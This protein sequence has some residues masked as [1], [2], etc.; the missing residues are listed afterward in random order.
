[1][2]VIGAGTMG[3]GIA[4]V[5]ARAG[6]RTLLHDR[7]PAAIDSAIVRLH[8]QLDREVSKGR[9]EET[10][11]N[12]IASRIEAAPQIA[13]LG[14]AMLLIE[15]ILENADA[16]AALFADLER[17][18]SPDAVLCSN[19][20]SLSITAIGAR[21]ARPERFAGM[22]FF[23]P[24][25][26]MP[27]VEVISGRATSPE[28]A[29]QLAATAKAWG[30]VPVYC[31]ST[32]GFIVNRIARPFY[33]EG[34]RLIE[35]G[36]GDPATID[37]IMTGCGGFRMGPMALTDLIGQDVNFAVTQS[38][39]A[40]TF[41]D[42]RYSPSPIQRDLVEAGW[43]GRKSGRGFY[44]YSAGAEP[45]GPRY[46]ATCPVPRQVVFRGD[47]GPA[48][49]LIELARQSGIEIAVTD[50]SGDMSVNGVTVAL[51]D[52]R[53]AS[54]RAQQADGDVIL[55]D[56]AHDYA[57]CDGIGLAANDRASPASRDAAAGFFQAMGKWV[58]YIDDVPGLV[59]ARTVALLVREAV[60]IVRQGIASAEDVDRAMRLGVNYPAGP[61][62]W[63]S[64]IGHA[65]LV[66]L[67]DN[68]A[69]IYGEER[70]RAGPWLRRMALPS[71]ALEECR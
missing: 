63:A 14:E 52:G 9:L 42:V 28:V 12:A 21:L 8:S 20:S 10:E 70:Y 25:D 53:L 7:D 61:I 19:T 48:T 18:I 44:D 4:L 58:A 65:R 67:L 31:R 56:L 11:R 38:V 39:F 34:L 16:K 60:Q 69:R 32:P 40:A 37:A 24:A 45:P 13:D 49:P 3:A 27:L 5:A 43:L 71:L 66:A 17:I 64:E 57:A 62:A 26:R 30:K 6:H 22:H 2:A 68:L 59:V 29:A 33:A 36:A 46:H 55:F 41:H 15:V 50:G 47:L 1:M 35:D 51:T 23:N 54:E